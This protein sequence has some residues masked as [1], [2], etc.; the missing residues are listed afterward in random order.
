MPDRAV[1]CA[2]ASSFFFISFV[3]CCQI[4]YVQTFGPKF[5]TASN[6]QVGRQLGSNVQA[7]RNNLQQ[8]DLSSAVTPPSADLP[9]PLPIPADAFPFFS[10]PRDPTRQKIAVLH[11]LTANSDAALRFVLR[12]I[13][14]PKEGRGID[15]LVIC[16][17]SDAVLKR[18]GFSRPRGSSFSRFLG[19]KDK[20]RAASASSSSHSIRG[21]SPPRPSPVPLS[22]AAQEFNL[23]ITDELLSA[24]TQG[25]EVVGAT[26]EERIQRVVLTTGELNVKVGRELLGLWTLP[27]GRRG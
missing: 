21:T 4:K 3:P 8:M 2:I 20:D 24:P 14:S 16:V 26:L 1:D 19:N 23:E 17:C 5:A 18:A 25:Q 22:E 27:F 12:E 11:D 6:G 15:I 9:T 13:F 7:A 10:P